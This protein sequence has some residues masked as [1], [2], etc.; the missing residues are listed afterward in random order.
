[1]K[2]LITS[3]AL[4]MLFAVSADAG[5]I[6]FNDYESSG[7]NQGAGLGIQPDSMNFTDGG[8][9]LNGQPALGLSTANP[10]SGA[11]S[12]VVDAGDIVDNGNG[13]GGSWSGIATDS[14][15]QNGGLQTQASVMAAGM[16]SYVNIAAG[17]TF[18]V[19]ALVATDAADPATGG[20]VAQPRLEFHN[21]AGMELF[22]N[23]AGTPFTAGTLTPAYQS[24][25]HS[26]TL[27]AADIAA[28][29]VRVTA[30]LGT[31]G[32]GFDQNGG[33]PQAD[34]LVYYDDLSFEVSDA[35]IV[36]VVPEPST[37]SLLVAGL[38]GLCGV[39]RRRS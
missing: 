37:A 21:A 17:A 24:I 8:G 20:V 23:D 10:S 30:V 16:G 4:A 28:G 38:M 9:D 11:Y 6:H 13:W 36:T 12:Y 25:T 19:S 34:G 26:Y 7:A 35:F 33:G 14:G 1:M 3:M 2:T 29:V 27:T 18:T 15:Q 31:D 32:H 39:R 5:V 22:R